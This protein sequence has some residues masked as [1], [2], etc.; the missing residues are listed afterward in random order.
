MNKI[1]PLAAIIAV[2]FLGYKHFLH[3]GDEDAVEPMQAKAPAT[4]KIVDVAKSVADYSH[5]GDANIAR[6]EYR[7]PFETLSFFG[8]K[9]SHKVVEILPGS[10]WY[11]EI[12]APKLKVDGQLVAAHYPK[13]EGDD[14]YRTKARFDFEDKLKLD[15]DVYGEVSITDFNPMGKV[16]EVTK[17]SDYVL[18]FRS[19]HGFQN[20]GQLSNA[21]KQFNSMLKEGGKL[22]VVQHEA[23]EGSDVAKVSKLGYLPKSFVIAEAEKAGFKLVASSSINSNPKDIIV[24]EGIETGVWTLPPSLRG[25]GDVSR[26]KEIGESN[27]MTLLFVKQ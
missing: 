7:H 3:T 4:L 17:D 10:G 23:P 21:F 25:E 24:Q 11:T 14:S 5:R 2:A 18:T 1:I 15:L 8:V 9:S 19:L 6:D 13:L 20:K 16:A 12:L 26:F 27:R 22:G